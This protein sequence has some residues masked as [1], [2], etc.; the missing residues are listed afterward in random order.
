[1]REVDAKTAAFE[2]GRAAW[3]SIPLD[4]TTFARHTSD[5][6][7]LP[8]DPTTQA[9]DVYLASACAQGDPEAL[10]VFES[11]DIKNVDS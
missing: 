1:M 5:A 3:P 10:R 9:R 7:V 4:F 6:G 2:E 11:Q 8:R